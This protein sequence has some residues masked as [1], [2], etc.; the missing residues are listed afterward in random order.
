MLLLIT[1]KRLKYTPLKPEIPLC[2]TSKTKVAAR[3]SAFEPLLG[4]WKL[5]WPFCLYEIV[6]KQQRDKDKQT[7]YNFHGAESKYSKAAHPA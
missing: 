6:I 7:H 3:S 1:E 2:Y 4:L 5:P